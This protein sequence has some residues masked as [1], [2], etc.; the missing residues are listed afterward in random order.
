LVIVKT[1]SRSV[2]PVVFVSIGALRNGETKWQ[3]SY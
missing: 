2:K 3:L 1:A